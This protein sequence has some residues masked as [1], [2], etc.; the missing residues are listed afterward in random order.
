MATGLADSHR[1]Y[2]DNPFISFDPLAGRPEY[3]IPH[4][5]RHTYASPVLQQGESVAYVQC[6]LDHTSI[7]LT[8]DTYGKWLPLRSKAAVD[9]LNQGLGLARG[10]KVV[11]TERRRAV[12]V[13]ELARG[14][15]PPTCGLQIAP[16]PFSAPSLSSPEATE[17]Q[18][19]WPG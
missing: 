5:L 4:C 6:Q 16:D 1:A 8:V 10:S 15:E 3:F 18:E 2:D 13:L 11:A 7:Q 12:Y 19:E 9:R 14:I 17:S